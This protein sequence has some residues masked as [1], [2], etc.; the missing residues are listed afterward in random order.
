ME[1]ASYYHQLNNNQVQCNL[2]P[3][4][5]IINENAKGYCQA[6]ANINGELYS[7]TNKQYS[8]V[9]ID[10]IEKKPLLHYYPGQKILSLGS[11][12]CNLR[13]HH[14]QNWEISQPFKENT[15]RALTS[16]TPDEIVSMTLKN[17]IQLIAFTYNEPSIGYES[18]LETAK[19]AYQ[20]GIKIVSVT[21]GYINILPLKELATVVAAYSVDLKAFTREAYNELTCVDAFSSVKDTIEFLVSQKK[22]VEI[23]TNLVT[24]INDDLDQ[25]ADAAKWIKNIGQD[26]PWHI[27]EYFPANDYINREY[28][29][30]SIAIKAREN[31]LKVG[32]KFVY[33]NKYE[34]TICPFCNKII[35]SRSRFI[36]NSAELIGI[37]C[38]YCNNIIPNLVN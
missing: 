14:C 29:A 10:P 18:M 15:N 24:G 3:N 21:N 11:L 35:I 12:G 16:L 2:C 31:A 32:L 22:H 9:A 27:S 26:I 30:P 1:K 5:C 38:K 4:N 17:A 19:R 7:L 33:T 37:K 25:L 36:V 20:K 34:D 28:I 13:C 23:V 6:R 8:S